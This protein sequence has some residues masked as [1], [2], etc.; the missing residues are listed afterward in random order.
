MYNQNTLKNI[1]RL[2]PVMFF[3]F[4]T[5]CIP[6]REVTVS[7][8]SDHLKYLAS[9]SL[10]GRLTGSSGDSLAAEY[11]RNELAS[12]G[13]EPLT[14][15]G[16]QRFKVTIRLV[17][18]PGNSMAVNG[19]SLVPEQD[20]MPF[21]FSSNTG[22]EA[23]VIFVGYGF[24]INEE[25]LKWND[26]QG[27]DVKGKWALMLRSDPEADNSTSQFIPNSGDRIK[28]L[29]A[30]DMGAAGVLLVSG[31]GFDPQDTFESLNATDLSTGIPVIRIKREAAERILAKNNRTI[32]ELEKILNDKR[33]PFSFATGTVVNARAEIVRE[34]GN[35]RNVV[36]LLPGEDESLKNEYV[37]IGAHFDHLGMGGS[38]SMTP[39]SAA[40]HYGADDNASGVGMML[41]IAEKFALSKGSHLRS[42]ICV[43]FTGEE[44]GVLGSKYFVNNPGIDMTK[45]N[46]MINLDM[47]GRLQES[48][49]LQI[50]GVG[51]SSELKKIILANCDTTVIKLVLS[52]EGYGPSDHSS[53]Y[54]KN[55]P[56]LFYTT[57][58]HL[59]CHTPKDT[60]DKINYQ[61]MVNISSLIFDVTRQLVSDPDRQIFREA[62]P[63]ED[64]GRPMRRKSVTLGIMPD[65]NGNE[66]SGLRAD[67]VT[68]GKPAARGGMKNGDIITSIN[69]KTIS[70]I[71]DYM[72]RMGQL[73]NSQTITVEVLRDGNKMVLIIQL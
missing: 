18:G 67:I 12:C 73:K 65:F 10:K 22:F 58:A 37:I 8:L 19:T 6:N 14:G 9:D 32:N 33:K 48:N 30:K 41:E 24:N 36:M 52:D 54:A 2:L 4:L 70:N 15:D 20:F 43:A 64:Q 11:I 3:I 40:V 63:K 56:V 38:A 31:T 71:Y 50:S 16:F 1:T 68:P 49:I 42:I 60:Y 5:S 46:A 35:T 62:G 13:F 25:R 72:S 59:D 44:E 61:G 28:A 27:I 45:V 39:D 57:G 66:K 21:S 17:A 55:I 26:Y 47:V 51:T 34:T 29:V 23:E 7:E 69:G 53:F